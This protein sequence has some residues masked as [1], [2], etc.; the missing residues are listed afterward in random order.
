M[1]P[2]RR[3]KPRPNAVHSYDRLEHRLTL[4][5]WLHDR[6]GYESTKGLLDDIRPAKEGF[7]ADGRSDICRRLTT[8][9]NLRVCDVDLRRYDDN[10]REHLAAMNTGRTQPI[11]LRYF[12]YLAALYTRRYFSTTARK[13][14]PSCSIL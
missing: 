12:Q 3:A 10:I 2:R 5:S 6:L 13:A 9:A 14:P 11:T 4:L 1:P 8:R 7:G